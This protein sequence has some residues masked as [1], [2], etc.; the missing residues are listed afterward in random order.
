MEK[1]NV[2]DEQR[3]KVSEH[4][5][6]LVRGGVP[7]KSEE[8]LFSDDGQPLTWRR[9]EGP[10]AAANYALCRCG[11]SSNKPFCD[12][13][14]AKI[15]W[16]STDNAPG[17][18]ADNARHL[19]S[20][21][22]DIEDFRGICAH[23]GMCTGATTDVWKLAHQTADSEKRAEVISMIENCPSGAL[24]YALDGIANEP[25]IPAE[26]GVIPNGPLWVTDGIPVERS[27][28][29]N[30]ETRNRV[31][32]CRCGGSGIKPL[33][34]GTHREIWGTTKPVAE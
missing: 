17:P 30:L 24:T 27:T 7:L 20:E 1:I 2:S 22:P 18:Y 29:D 23:V 28:G 13:T 31:T 9:T 32:L 5:P 16:D 4:G 34:D 3:I 25:N 21:S 6:Y 10:E 14:H 12:G 8:P 33:C 15:E 19:A 26:I 11:G